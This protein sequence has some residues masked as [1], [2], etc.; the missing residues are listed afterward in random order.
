MRSRIWVVL[1]FVIVSALVLSACAAP[2]AP[3]AAPAAP[4]A[5]TAAPAAPTSAPAQ[6]TQAVSAKAPTD[7]NVAAIFISTVEEPWNTSWLQAMDRLKAAKPNGATVNVDYTENVFP[8]DA[9]RVLRQYAQTGKYQ[10]IWAHSAYPDAVKVLMK[11]FPDILWVGAGSGY[12]PM[13]GN[14]YWVDVNVHEPAYLAGIIAG[15]MTKSNVVG[16][17]GGF[18]YP[19]VNLP[20]NGFVAGAKSVNPDVKAKVTFIDSWFDPAKAKESAMAQIAAGADFVY[21]ERFGPFEAAQQKNILAFGHFVDQ[22]SIAPQV[23]TTSALALWDPTIKKVVDAWWDHATK[24][25]AYDAP[26]ER[27]VYN[28]KDGGADLAPY[29]D[30]GSKIPKDVQDAVAQAKADIMSGKLTVPYLDQ[31]PA[32]AGK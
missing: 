19:N 10:V 13:G 5:P 15:K 31:P 24:S 26:K 9:E 7:L 3:P 25:A 28:M 20:I 16:A 18:P 8:P 22:S 4:A 32:E 14:A 12:E 1:L 2:A 27:I 23:V 17:V 30:L 11:E 6:P 21:A 29:H